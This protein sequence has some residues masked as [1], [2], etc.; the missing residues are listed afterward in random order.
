VRGK[1][2]C[3]D[4]LAGPRC[5]AHA[6]GDP[7]DWEAPGELG[8]PPPPLL[9][10]PLLGAAAAL[11]I[12]ACTAIALHVQKV[13]LF[14]ANTHKPLSLLPPP[15][16]RFQPLALCRLKARSARSSDRVR[17]FMANNLPP[18]AAASGRPA[19]TEVAHEGSRLAHTRVGGRSYTLVP[20]SSEVQ[21]SRIPQLE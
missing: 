13:R 15:L 1:C 8:P 16:L 17:L 21:L 12:V 20:S 10:R 4:G 11:I 19:G 3:G 18:A 6:G 2:A 5:L 14:M 7:V 9:P